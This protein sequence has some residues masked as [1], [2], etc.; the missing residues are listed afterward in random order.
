MINPICNPLKCC[1]AV[2]VATM[3][4]VLPTTAE[5]A[6][7]SDMVE[8]CTEA[9]DLQSIASKDKYRTKMTKVR[10]GALKRLTLDVIPL[11]NGDE[12]MTVECHVKGGEVVK[13]SVK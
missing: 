7:T 4:L 13:L 8:M 2:M 12:K 3:M 9:L 10:G 5:A 1:A 6:S 11:E